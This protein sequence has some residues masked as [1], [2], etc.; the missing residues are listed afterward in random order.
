MFP[1]NIR[2]YGLLINEWREVL[3][4]DEYRNGYAFTKFPGGGLEFGEGFK[5]TLIREFQEEL[6]LEITVGE[7][8]YFNDFH[9]LS[10]FDQRH[11]VHSFY[12]RVDS[13]DWHLISTN[14]HKIPLEE[15]G[16]RQRWVSIDQMIPE[17][18]TFPLD[19]IV[20]EKLKH[21]Q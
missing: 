10:I 2:V 19:K 21:M 3:L 18:L 12:Y 1:F 8:F 14:G 9:Q 7:L 17:M 6:N 5:E 13:P 16:E 11:Q 15:E 4:S 20:A